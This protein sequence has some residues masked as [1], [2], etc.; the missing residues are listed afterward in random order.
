MGEFAE[1]WV[2]KRI[3]LRKATERKIGVM[4]GRESFRGQPFLCAPRDSTA[5]ALGG[6]RLREVVTQ[7]RC[8]TGPSVPGAVSLSRD[9][10]PTTGD[11]L[12]FVDSSCEQGQL[13]P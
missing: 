10:G 12:F 9:G 2:K 8:G 11:T 4:L 13:F 5:R 7:Q 6:T 1:A 3:H